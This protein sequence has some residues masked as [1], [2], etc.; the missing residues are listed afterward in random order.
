MVDAEGL[1]ELWRRGRRRLTLWTQVRGVR[2]LRHDQARVDLV[3]GRTI[4]L[5]SDRV[6]ELV[7]DIT[8]CVGEAQAAWSVRGVPPEQ[9][10]AWLRLKPGGRRTE[11][12][13]PWQMLFGLLTLGAGAVGL[14]IQATTWAA[15]SWLLLGS[16]LLLAGLLHQQ[17]VAS[18][19]E[20]G[21]T[22]TRRWR[23]WRCDWPELRHARP[24]EP[25]GQAVRY[26]LLGPVGER[27]CLLSR[28]SAIGYT[29]A[30]V[31]EANTA[32][33]RAPGDQP[34]P[35]PSLSLTRGEAEPSDRD[36]SRMGDEGH[37]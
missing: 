20:Q 15:V 12:P 3:D 22:I 1:S 4:D 21:L 16:V 33:F 32:T 9:I 13:H 27:T 7:T 17:P 14:C 30:R 25:L 11:D 34:V 10:R 31:V 35:D 19:D 18:A 28:R 36:L 23:Q 29:I 8:R 5:P 37:G 26:R 6:G 2:W 24:P